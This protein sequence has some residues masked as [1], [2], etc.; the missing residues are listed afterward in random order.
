LASPDTAEVKTKKLK[1]KE[2]KL[3]PH[4]NLKPAISRGNPL[5]KS[6]KTRARTSKE[7]TKTIKTGMRKGLHK[8]KVKGHIHIREESNRPLKGKKEKTTTGE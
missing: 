1:T 6:S 8:S 7:K 3:V 5:K 2:R 4:Q